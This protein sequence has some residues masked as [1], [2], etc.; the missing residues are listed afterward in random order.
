MFINQKPHNPKTKENR[1]RKQKFQIALLDLDLKVFK[2]VTCLTDDKIPRTECIDLKGSPVPYAFFIN[3][4]A[5]GYAKF[6]IDERSLLN[7]EQTKLI[8]LEGG[9]NRKHM[10]MTLYDMIKSHK[11]AGSRVLSFMANNVAD[12]TA[13]DVI[14][15]VLSLIP[16]Q[17]V[18]INSVTGYNS[19]LFESVISLLQS[20]KFTAESTKQMLINSLFMFCLSEEHIGMLLQYFESGKIT[21][22]N[23]KLISESITTNQRHTMVKKIF[24]STSIN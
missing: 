2:T 1:L 7:L 18:P 13:E 10:Y 14:T 12:E 3:Y 20:G 6:V 4:G 9:M 17:F 8:N 19:K 11:V 22:T 16:K 23:G 24:A 21:S 5:H 15:Y